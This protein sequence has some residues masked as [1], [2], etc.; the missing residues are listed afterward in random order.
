[1]IYSL[2]LS[3]TTAQFQTC[4]SEEEKAISQLDKKIR[5]QETKIDKKRKD[6]GG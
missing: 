1:M 2:L 3:F 6:M 4:I 5:E